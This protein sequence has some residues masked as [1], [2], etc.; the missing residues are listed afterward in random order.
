MRNRPANFEHRMIVRGTSADQAEI[1]RKA[2]WEAAGRGEHAHRRA[3]EASR[4]RTGPQSL[5]ELLDQVEREH[6]QRL[7]DVLADDADD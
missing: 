2:R 3:Q 5:T 4:R 6:R 7:D 1:V